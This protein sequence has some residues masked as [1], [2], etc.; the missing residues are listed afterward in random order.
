[1]LAYSHTGALTVGKEAIEFRAKG[2]ELH[3]PYSSVLDVRWGKFGMDWHNKWAIVKFQ[4]EG[5]EKVAGFAE[6]T[7]TR[8]MYRTLM[9]AYTEYAAS[10]GGK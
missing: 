1:L 6:R 7:R 5:S 2:K 4:A 10:E 3:I 9:K 8:E